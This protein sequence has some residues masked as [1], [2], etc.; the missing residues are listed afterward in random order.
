MIDQTQKLSK[1]Y[2]P[3]REGVKPLKRSLSGYETEMFVLNEEGMLDHSGQLLKKAKKKS[4]DVKKE[5]AKS[6]V[7]IVCMPHKR[8]SSTGLNLLDRLIR[9]NELAEQEGY[10]LYPFSTYPGLNEAVFRK[11]E[12]YAIQQKILGK[13]RFRNAGLCCGF[14][15]HY[16][17]PRGAFDKKTQFL[18]YSVNSKINRTLLGSYNLLIAMDPILT[19]FLQSSPYV[20][21]RFLAKD[22]RMLLY[23]GGKKLKFQEGLYSHHQFFGGLPP[24]KQT[25]KDLLSTLQRRYHRWKELLLEGGLELPASLK[26]GSPLDSCWNPVR[27]NS[28]GTLEYRGGDMNYPSVL[29]GVSTLIKFALRKIQQDFMMVIPLDMELKDAFKVEKNLLF[30]PPHALVRKRLQRHSA[31]DGLASKDLRMYIKAFLRFTKKEVYTRYR[32]LLSPIFEMVDKK[33]S[34]SDRILKKARRR[35]YGKTIPPSFAK[36]LGL[37]YSSKLSRDLEKTRHALLRVEGY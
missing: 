10:A 30:I 37:F 1:R 22:S 2:F 21:N 11:K 33:Q 32:P 31:Y 23:R 28:K 27:I 9:M 26:K 13:S 3:K 15:Q 19:T 7:E 35:G 25:M 6:M 17:L 5:C 34:I 12:D 4:I 14:H 36:E 18:R 24:Y 29:F 20:N 8:L 16:T